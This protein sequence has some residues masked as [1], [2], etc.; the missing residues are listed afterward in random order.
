M[1]IDGRRM[2][3]VATGALGTQA[4]VIGLIHVLPTGHDPAVNFVSEYAIGTAA[5]WMR[6]VQ[7]AGI[8]GMA[9]LIAALSARGVASLRSVVGGLLMLNVASRILNAIFEVDPIEHAFAGGGPP[10]FTTSGWVHAVSGMVGAVTLIVVM[11]VVTVQMARARALASWYRA[12]VPLC[13]VTPVAYG[14][15][16][17]TRPATFPAGIYQRI[18]IVCALAWLIGLGMGM[19]SGRLVGPG[20]G[21]SRA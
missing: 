17:S 6:L 9:A 18:F 21:E 14:A 8:V 12:L 20:A 5:P 3:L 19:A 7:L 2:A 11:I 1:S 16:L 13:I 15:M 4:V 10:R